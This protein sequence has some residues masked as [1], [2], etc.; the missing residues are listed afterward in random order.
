VSNAQ[1]GG[2]H[3]YISNP[4]IPSAGVQYLVGGPTYTP[5]PTYNLNTDYS[6]PTYTSPNTFLPP[7]SYQ[8]VTNEYAP[9]VSC[10]SEAVNGAYGS[11]DLG[12]YTEDVLQQFVAGGVYNGELISNY[13][14][15]EVSNGEV[16]GVAAGGFVGDGHQG[17]MNLF[18][19]QWR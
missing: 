13:G 2:L 8:V 16:L 14:N 11:Q 15:S 1:Y 17:G 19:G 6:A 7:E 12:A 5:V 9:P 4:G 10:Y 3:H 18:E